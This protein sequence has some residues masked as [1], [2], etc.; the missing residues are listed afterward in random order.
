MEQESAPATSQS[1][2]TG[3]HQLAPARGAV[4]NAEKPEVHVN[5]RPAAGRN[6][7][8]FLYCGPIS[9]LGDSIRVEELRIRRA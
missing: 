8:I 4:G 2:F 5:R 6:R 7:L 3:E 9:G 1:A